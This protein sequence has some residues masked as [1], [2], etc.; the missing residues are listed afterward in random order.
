M[1]YIVNENGRKYLTR[2]GEERTDLINL[3][4]DDSNPIV[5]EGPLEVYFKHLNLSELIKP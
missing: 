4:D 5:Y 1:V 3:C 2:A